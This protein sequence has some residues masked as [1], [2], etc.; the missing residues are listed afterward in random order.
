MINYKHIADFSSL[1]FNHHVN[2]ICNIYMYFK[3]VNNNP[4]KS[5]AV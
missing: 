4:V 5:Y 1:K 3:T 2:N